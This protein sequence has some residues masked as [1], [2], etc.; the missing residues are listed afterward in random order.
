ME[1]T[2][3]M[4]RKFLDGFVSQNHKTGWFNAT[5]LVS[6]A[7]KYRATQGETPKIMTDYFKKKE[8]QEFI[9]TIAR[10]EEIS[11]VYK[12]GRGRKG[13]TWV[14]PLILI[15]IAMWLSQDFKYQALN[16]LQDNLL[17]Y[18]DLSGD[19]YKLLTSAICSKINPAKAGVMIPDIA[20]QIKEKIKV[21][22]WNKASEEQLKKRLQVQRD[23]ILL[24]KTPIGLEEAVKIAL[25]NL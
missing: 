7:N 2:Q 21:E 17:K 4:T 12:I 11:Q 25:D 10:K 15:D 22:D 3:I 24:C 6:I 20:R 16:W 18:R 23:I 13:G 14:H 9:S 1:T 8:T 19:D 5:E